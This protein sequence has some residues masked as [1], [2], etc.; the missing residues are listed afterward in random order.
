MEQKQKNLH[1]RR[2]HFVQ[3]DGGLTLQE[4]LNQALNSRKIIRNRKEELGQQSGQ[5]GNWC[6]FIN[7]HQATHGMEFGVLVF[8][9]PGQNKLVI[10]NH[11]DEDQV[12]VSQIRPP[13]GKDF[14]ES[15][16]Y[17]GIK[18][19]HVIV[20]QTIGLMAKQ[21]ESH[22]FWLLGSTCA[23]ILAKENGVFLD[24]YAPKESYQAVV[25][26]PVKSVNMHVPI[27]DDAT[28]N[29]SIQTHSE[30]TRS[31]ATINSSS[32]NAGTRGLQ[33]LKALLP[34][35]R[36][37]TLIDGDTISPETDIEVFVEV[38]KKRWS[39]VSESS[40]DILN[41]VANTMRYVDSDGVTINLSDGTKLTGDKLTIKTSLS[42]D[43]V[44]GILDPTDVFRQMSNWLRELIKN[45]QIEA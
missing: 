28:P 7:T 26:N 34:Q 5:I 39:K 13:K 41:A 24:N 23:G 4:C 43:S 36:Y 27:V 25:E 33:V 8:L 31:R 9:E 21:L 17:Y 35:D 6:R 29:T 15:T 44:G 40:Q 10:E 32:F 19:N 22:L 37:E 20:L 30:S 38:K 45:E 14:M 11:E 18:D 1:Y 42:F 3:G 12:N 2:A 16:L